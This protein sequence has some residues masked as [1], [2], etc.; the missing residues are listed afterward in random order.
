MKKETKNTLLYIIVA[1]IIG[2]ISCLFLLKKGVIV[3]HDLEYHLSRIS[4]ISNSLRVGDFKAL[5]HNPGFYN[6]GYANGLFYS[7]LFLYLPAL[8]KLIGLNIITSYK[9]FIV[10][11]TILT[12]ISMFY[13]TKSITKSN[14][15]AL[16]SSVL[17]T[18]CSYRI[19]DVIVRAAIGEVLSFIF[20]PI[21]ILG[22]YEI[23]FG[24]CKKWYIFTF[25]FVGLINCH[26]IS[27]VM[28]AI[29]IVIIILFNIFRLFKEKKRLFSL[30]ISAIVGLLLGAFFII[31]M[32]QQYVTSDLLINSKTNDISIIMPFFKIFVG[33][34]NY[35]TK[36]IPGGIGLVYF[37]LIYLRFKIKEKNELLQFS[38]LMMTI[39]IFT[40]L[41]STDI[42][43]WLEI[44]PLLGSI[45]YTWRLFLFSSFFLSLSGSIVFFQWN[46]E[47][48]NTKFIILIVYI[49]MICFINQFLSSESL[50]TYYS[51]KNVSYITEYKDFT[52]AAGEYLPKNTD[53]SLIYTDKRKIKS[54]SKNIKINYKEKNGKYYIN[55]KNNDGNY[56]DVP[57]IY[58]RGYKANSVNNNKEYTV[59]YG[60]NTWCRI[61]I[62]NIKK[63]KIIL[64][65]KGTIITRISYLISII[66]LII[67]LTWIYLNKKE[68]KSSKIVKTK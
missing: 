9:I 28:M 64:E 65:Y 14:K 7:N 66:S 48:K 53:W 8:L 54:D 31:P 62:N 32:L 45:Q 6:Y 34:P 27:T 20:V 12:S 60:Y 56:I 23:L 21:I 59:G 55:F 51:P 1:V 67:L 50:K 13:C 44:S 43:P 37:F 42:V 18:L 46:K 35:K 47:K 33:I 29:I 10:I 57:L 17:Y 38:D 52:V 61:Y 49:I 63:D 15:M 25:G 4:G 41:A 16:L 19:C 11:C 68:L 5:I 39:G 30:I 26:I 2:I 58:Y 36:F 22:L 40:L 24:N 3:G